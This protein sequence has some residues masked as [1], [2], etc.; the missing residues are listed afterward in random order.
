VLTW[1][2]LTPFALGRLTKE[3]LTVTAYTRMYGKHDMLCAL[4]TERNYKHIRLSFGRWTRRGGLLTMHVLEQPLVLDLVLQ[5]AGSHQWLFLGAVSKAW[6]ALYSSMIHPCLAR[7]QQG[8][9]SSLIQTKTT[10]FAKAAAA[11]PRALY[12]CDC[13]ETLKTDKLL[14]L[15]RA[16]ASC[17]CSHVLIW[18]Q[19]V[20]SFKWL[21]WHHQLCMAAAAGNQLAT[22]QE[23]RTSNGPQQLQW[24]VVKVAAKAAECADLSMLQWVV[25][26]QPKWTATGIETVGEGAAG[27]ADAVEKITWL[28]KRFPSNRFGLQFAFAL[29]TLKCGAVALL[30]WLASVGSLFGQQFY[31]NTATT[32]GQLAV[33]RYLVEEAGCPWDATKVRKAA[34]AFDSAEMLEWASNAD[35]AIWTTTQLSELL[36]VACEGNKL[37]AAVWL[38]AAGAEWP[39]SFL[40]RD[41]YYDWTVWPIQAMKWA[42]ANG[43]PWGVWTPKTCTEICFEGWCS[44]PPNQQVTQDAMLWD[45][46]LVAPVAAGSIA[47]QVDWYATTVLAAAAV[48][49]VR[50]AAVKVS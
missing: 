50:A 6:A 26:Q 19:A 31:T 49:A 4:L 5:Y 21:E 33:L 38:R 44:K 16:A 14:L 28:C 29:A 30:R 25:R 39:S 24:K 27:A 7:E 10:S 35:D 32:A 20:A 11:L 3:R 17:G 13:D 23:L 42:R 12:A 18:A 40:C 15:S 22:L 34:L 8:L 37:C 46:L 36:V 41:P 2:L 45:T 1:C 48:A 47:L 9:P 43:C